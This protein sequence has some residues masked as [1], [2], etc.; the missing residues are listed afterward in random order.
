MV[1]YVYMWVDPMEEED[2]VEL[3]ISQTHFEF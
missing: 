2:M 1:V 3:E